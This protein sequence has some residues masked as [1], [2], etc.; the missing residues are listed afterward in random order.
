M[1]DFIAVQED[2]FCLNTQQAAL[3]QGQNDNVG[4][5][6]HFTGTVRGGDDCEALELEHYPGMTEKSLAEIVVQAKARWPLLAV[7]IIHRVGKLLPG[8]Q[9]V[10]VGVASRHRQAAF[11]ACHFIM[12]YL[13]TQAPFWKKE[14]SANGE[15][16]VDARESDTDALT[17]WQ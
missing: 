16:W 7:R 10:Y 15:Q 9:I 1:S 4:G 3:L 6:C 5:C 12:D 17:R 8:E 11:E 2:D 14:Y 13:K